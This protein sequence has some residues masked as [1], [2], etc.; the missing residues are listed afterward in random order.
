ML[1]LQEVINDIDASKKKRD[2]IGMMSDANKE[3]FKQM[4]EG[5]FEAVLTGNG[6][7]KCLIPEE[8]FPFYL[9]R[10]QNEEVVPCIPSLY[11][12][13]PTDIDIFLNK[14]RL[15]AFK[16]LLES[17]PIVNGFF[18]KNHF[19]VDVEGLAQHYGLKTS[20]LDLTRSLD[21]AIFFAVCK[22]NRSTNQYEYYDDD[23]VH[24][25]ILYVFDP[26]F[27]NEPV[28]SHEHDIYNGNIRP[29]GL[30]PFRRPA[31]QKG[32]SLHIAKGS[33]VKCYMYRFQFTSEDSKHY[34]ELF[35]E[36]YKLWVQ[37]RL[38]DK[39]KQ[40]SELKEFSFRIFNEACTY[41]KPKGFLKKKLMLE[42][43]KKGISFGTKISPI[44]FSSEECKEII[45]EWNNV[46]GKKFADC[47]VRKP[48]FDHEGID[49]ERNING[50][51]NRKN[52]RN[53]QMLTLGYILILIASPGRPIGSEWVNYTN[54]PAPTPKTKGH[55]EMI[56][57][58][59]TE[60]FGKTYLTEDDWKIK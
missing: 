47:I 27:D 13:N 54:T 2:A 26:I 11:R 5:H 19:I 18:K 14:L 58:H 8:G 31:E 7:E 49:K 52:F 16:H 25:A 28:P 48:S 46:E 12:G 60:L 35:D 45:E 24:A 34:F 33:S 41:Y 39:A 56:P 21:V 32:F 51:K 22:F 50:I 1:T 17:Y 43:R 53:L 30:Q 42:L 6:D 20:V 37:D 3:I 15:V 4:T 10:G 57:A 36:G 23:Q 59:F 44:I 29:I 38:V 9:Y 40:I 55:G